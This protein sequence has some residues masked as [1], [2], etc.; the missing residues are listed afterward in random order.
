[1]MLGFVAKKPCGGWLD[2]AWS[3][4]PPNFG[5]QVSSQIGTGPVSLGQRNQWNRMSMAFN[6]LGRILLVSS[7][8][9]V[10]LS[11]WMGVQ[12]CGCP[13]SSSMHCME[14]AVLALMNNA[15]SSASA[16]DDITALIIC[17]I[18]STTPLLMGMSSVPAI[19]MWPPALLRALGSDRYNALLCIASLIS[20]A[21]YVTIASSCNA[22]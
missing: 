2:D 19:N 13:I 17:K 15:P 4:N 3:S 14:T 11:F 10:K 6:A 8:W 9:A 18:L 21:R 7:A 16:A 12:V 20:L 22:V 5:F 1:M